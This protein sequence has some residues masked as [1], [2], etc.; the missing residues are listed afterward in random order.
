MKKFFGNGIKRIIGI[1]SCAG[2]LLSALSGMPMYAAAES[3]ESVYYETF[4]NGVQGIRGTYTSESGSSR[5][6][7]TIPN[8]GTMMID[9]K[10][11]GAE[12]NFEGNPG[13]NVK[14][15]TAD[16]Q[17]MLFEFLNDVTAGVVSYSFDTSCLDRAADWKSHI[18]INYESAASVGAFVLYMDAGKNIYGPANNLSGWGDKNATNGEFNTNQK[19]NVK[20]VFDMTNRKCYTC[21]D[22]VKIGETGIPQ[23]LVLKNISFWLAGSSAYFDNLKIQYSDEN[24]LKIE[25][26]KINKADNS[27]DVLY[28]GGIDR[29]SMANEGYKITNLETGEVYTAS[30]ALKKANILSL[31]SDFT[32]KNEGLYMIDLPEMT[33]TANERSVAQTVVV[34]RD[35]EKCLKDF[36]FETVEGGLERNQ[37]KV[38]PDIKKIYLSFSPDADVTAAVESAKIIGDNDEISFQRIINSEDNSAE[39]VLDRCFWGDSVYKISIKDGVDMPYEITVNTKPGSVKMINPKVYVNNTEVDSLKDIGDNSSVRLVVDI[40][41][42][43][44]QEKNLVFAYSLWNGRILSGFNY[45]EI[46]LND[47]D[48]TA[49]IEFDI[50]VKSANDLALKGMLKGE[51]GTVNLLGDYFEIK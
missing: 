51:L 2:V 40:V 38:S 47:E 36:K 17:L 14:K 35:T 49:H 50:S 24:L 48:D 26:T 4:D 22:G 39:L 30:A 19:Y 29:A 10:N 9:T 11:C 23:A 18:K 5:F 16:T 37:N 21:V 20:Q 25:G 15:A 44:S 27:I 34:S 1:I 12:T 13:F 42:T 45:K 43:I 33:G 31:T 32:L 3:E 7:K 28:N 46:T 8:F 6:T 41:K